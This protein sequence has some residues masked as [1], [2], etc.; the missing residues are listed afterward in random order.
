MRKN[1]GFLG[2]IC[3]GRI[4]LLLLRVINKRTRIR[5]QNPKEPEEWPPAFPNPGNPGETPCTGEARKQK[6]EKE[7][8]Y[9]IN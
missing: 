6:I 3:R 7:K 5:V 1:A 4:I 2:K 8:T 9:Y